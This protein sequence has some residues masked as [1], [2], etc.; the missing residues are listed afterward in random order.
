[1]T[2]TMKWIAAGAFVL[3]LACLAPTTVQAEDA[4]DGL[5]LQL[6]GRATAMGT[7]NPPVMPR[8]RTASVTIQITRWTTDEEK[9]DLFNILVEDG[10]RGMARALRRQDQTGFIRVQGH[11]SSGRQTWFPSERLRYAREYVADNGARRLV[12]GFDRPLTMYETV[13]RPRW[14]NFDVTLVVV[15]LDAEGNG[16]GQLAIGVQLD[17]DPYTDTLT[18][19]NFGTEPV[20]LT[21]VRVE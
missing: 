5:P 17:V 10:Q 2:K 9:E 16:A 3:A 12:L 14:R 13:N 7:S 11:D 6:F 21:S 8:N 18:V 19:T 15:D 20:R 1:M 4:D